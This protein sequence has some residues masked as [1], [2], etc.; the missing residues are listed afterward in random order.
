[1]H[2]D[3]GAL[4][5]AAIDAADR[6]RVSVL[7]STGYNAIRTSHN[8]VSPAFLD[9]CDE[10]GILVMDEAFDCWFQG[11]NSADYHHDFLAWW[12]RDLTSMVMRDINRPSVIMWSIGNE[13]PGRD[14]AEGYAYA[15]NLSDF[16]RKLDAGGK[17][18]ITS[19]YPG[20][21]EAA[22]PYFAALDVAGYNYGD[23]RYQSDHTRVPTRVMVGTES[24]PLYTTTVWN[25]VM[26]APWV[27]GDFIWT[28]IDYIGESSIGASGHNAGGASQDFEAC[29]GYCTQPY[30]YHVAFCGDIDLVGHRK[31]QSY[32]RAV[33]W[34]H[35]TL[36]MA[37]HAPVAPGEHEVVDDGW[38]F[39]DERQSWTWTEADFAAART[40]KSTPLTVHVYANGHTIP[41]VGLTR[42]DAQGHVE[43]LGRQ[44]VSVAS[45]SASFVVAYVPGSLLAHGYDGRGQP[46]PGASRTLVSAGVP[47]HI[48]L[49]A[50]QL[51]M[52]A[53]RNDLSYITATVVD[54]QGTTVPWSTASV[55]FSVLEQA[56]GDA[57][58]LELLAVGSGDPLD[59][60]PTVGVSSRAAYRGRVVGIVRPLVGAPP[61]FTARVRATAAGGLKS[62]D[63]VIRGVASN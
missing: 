8:P 24:F 15:R 63:L 32:L 3:N 18:A 21:N 31:P 4:G 2:H 10:L 29:A 17:R 48:E 46:V 20:V 41:M 62:D 7:K 44:N 12:Q 25:H 5:A 45:F 1:V 33:M 13:I 37:V 47:H 30:P 38:G 39:P 50:D 53:D 34:G 26:A 60:S 35:S 55:T 42:V 40:N 56:G 54:A 61:D 27:V 22:D 43:D 36:E 28:A 58:A 59:R 49:S 16:I 9:A 11:K 14:S 23:A 52:S 57:P 51:T 19:A 6:R